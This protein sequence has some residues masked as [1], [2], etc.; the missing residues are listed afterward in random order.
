M[1]QLIE[2]RQEL[3]LGREDEKETLK[4]KRSW[5]TKICLSACRKGRGA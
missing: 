2:N 1:P 3:T 4:M 5:R